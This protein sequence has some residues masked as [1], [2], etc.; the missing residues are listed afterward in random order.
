[1]IIQ[2]AIIEGAGLGCFDA[3]RRALQIQRKDAGIA[4]ILTLRLLKAATRRARVAGQ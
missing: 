3:R 4:Q 2:L 1:M